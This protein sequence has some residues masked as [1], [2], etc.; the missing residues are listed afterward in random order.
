MN[1]KQQ[2]LASL[3]FQPQPRDIALLRDLFASRLLS[4]AHVAAF[5]FAGSAEAARKRLDI[6]KEAGWIAQRPRLAVGTPA[7]YHLARGGFVALQEH[8]ALRGYPFSSWKD[9][10]DRAKVSD[11]TVRHELAVMDVKAAFRRAIRARAGCEELEF[12]TWPKLCEI[13]SEKPE[14]L[15]GSGLKMR[16]TAPDGFLRLLLQP[17]EPEGFCYFEVDMGTE[18]RPELVLKLC[19]Y[20]DFYEFQ[21][22][23]AP[24][25]GK[26]KTAY[27]DFPFLVLF[28]AQ[29]AAQRNT[30]LE[31]ITRSR[32]VKM[33]W[34]ALAAARDDVERD[35]LGAIWISAGAYGKHL[36]DSRFDP[37]DF[38]TRGRE[39]T[40]DEFV[41]THVP[42][43]SLWAKKNAQP[44]VARVA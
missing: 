41:E 7:I 44:G 1:S 42:K 18:V 14:T 22:G 43:Q 37:H 13:Y 11:S 16:R 3:G 30:M 25:F 15:D 10:E 27:A 6:L 23:L 33:P 8:D 21:G 9:M 20:Q 4:L 5:H 19:G 40:R 39:V 34:R 17:Q 28:V 36:R 32:L 29:S 2:P 38:R 35:A 31:H 26:P 12:V 24:R